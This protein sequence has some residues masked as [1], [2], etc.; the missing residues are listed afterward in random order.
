MPREA[1]SL[2][3]RRVLTP[4]AGSRSPPPKSVPARHACVAPGATRGSRN[5]RAAWG[6]PHRWCRRGCRSRGA[7]N[8]CDGWSAPGS[9]RHTRHHR[10]RRHPAESSVLMNEPSSSRSRSGLAWARCSS[11]IRAGSILG[12]TVI[13]VSL[14]RSRFSQI[15]RR[16]TRWP[17]PTN[18]TRSPVS[19]HHCAG[20]H[21]TDRPMQAPDP[22]TLR[23]WI[24]SQARRSLAAT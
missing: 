24:P 20:L 14:L 9:R 6:S 19:V 23:C 1:T 21:F 18:T 15:T 11:S 16:I 2:S 8:R 17:S 5:P 4:R 10:P 3:I 7:G 12:S 22:G 13:V